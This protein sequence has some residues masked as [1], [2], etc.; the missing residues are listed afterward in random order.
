MGSNPIRVTKIGDLLLKIA[1]FPLSLASLP[2]ILR[3]ENCMN[4]GFYWPIALIVGS[5]V[6]YHICSKQTPAEIN[7]LAALTVTYAVGTVGAGLLYFL[8]NRGG[9]LLAEYSHLNWS[10]FVLGVVIVGLEAGAIS[11]YKLGW[12]MNTGQLVYSSILA[13]VLL[14]VGNILYHEPITWSKILGV[15]ICFLGLF[16]ITR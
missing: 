1:D 11:M 14:F 12:N 9:H 6:L 13:V 4:L 7:P 2:D 16:L 3:E 8:T 15:A 10:S 5:N